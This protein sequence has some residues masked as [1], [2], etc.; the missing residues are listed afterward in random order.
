MKAE[1]ITPSTTFTST[2][3][4]DSSS[5]SHYQKEDPNAPTKTL[6]RH[7]LD[8]FGN[9]SLSFP[10][11][12]SSPSSSS[13]NKNNTNPNA[14]NDNPNDDKN[15]DTTAAATSSNSTRCRFNTFAQ[16]L[17]RNQL[18]HLISIG[19]V[20]VNEEVITQFSHPI[21]KEDIVASKVK[22]DISQDAVMELRRKIRIWV[23]NKPEGVV[24]TFASSIPVS[25]SASATSK[26]DEHND[27]NEQQQ[28]QQQKTLIEFLDEKTDLLQTVQTEMTLST[29]AE[30]RRKKK[31]EEGKRKIHQSFP[32]FPVGRLDC[33]SCGLLL[34][35]NCGSLCERLLH[36][37][38]E[39]EKE[40]LV[41]LD[42]KKAD[43]I[44]ERFYQLMREGVSWK[45]NGDRGKSVTSKPCV[46][47]PIE[48]EEDDRH[49]F[50]IQLKEGMNRQIRNQTEAAGKQL[51]REMKMKVSAKEEGYHVSFLKRVSVGP[52]IHFEDFFGGKREQQKQENEE[53]SEV[54][55]EVTGLL[56]E[57]FLNWAFSSKENVMKDEV[58]G[59]VRIRSRNDDDTE[60]GD[61]IKKM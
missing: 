19:A 47:T 14:K 35:T 11:F 6:L 37:D 49:T 43:P 10:S 38:F 46:V 50:K 53:N 5:L 27:N 58:G 12:S 57:Q 30:R 48:D 61:D 29:R 42:R 23:L 20:K 33:Q 1:K 45:P 32:L 55:V 59:E 36:P 7:L 13:I 18:Q 3:S 17:N 26:T 8:L 54:A 24:T 16:R 9:R 31:E 2:S 21:N 56:K 22:I 39:H 51:L 44:P 25:A 15:K 60:E 28:Q 4:L 41:K 40:Y 52:L 34:L